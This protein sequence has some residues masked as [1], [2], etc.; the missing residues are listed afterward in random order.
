MFALN[1][2]SMEHVLVI[3]YGNPLRSDD[4]VAWQAA[5]E[6]RRDLPW[7]ARIICAHQLTP[8]VAEDVSRAD[9]VIFLDAS[10]TGK[11]GTVRCQAV[12]ARSRKPCFSH[13]LAPADL[14]GWC[15]RLYS[16]KPRAFLISVDGERF[17][18]G[19][20]LS[21]RAL[22]AVPLVVERVS[23]LI[24]HARQESRAQRSL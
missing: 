24:D 5:N 7:A 1:R 2:E 13:H 10:S 12:S 23:K 17:D 21:V 19:Q 18:Y 8:E 9:L 11:P 6:L 14:L 22:N 15:H 3:A 20:G 4:G 16:A